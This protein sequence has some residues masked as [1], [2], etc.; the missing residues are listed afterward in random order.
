MSPF[1]LILLLFS[2]SIS[3]SGAAPGP[4]RGSAMH[5]AARLQS[6]GMK[7]C[8]DSLMELRS[9]IGE[10]VLF[11]LNGET[12]L[13]PGCCRAIRVIE[14]HCWAAEVML[15]ALGFTPQEGDVLRGYCDAEA[16]AASPPPPPP[17]AQGPKVESSEP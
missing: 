8:W 7:L 1:L 17:I 9:C 4:W 13:G 2:S 3:I 14:H 5:L 12:Y 15:A 16:G 11:F 6:D 10:V